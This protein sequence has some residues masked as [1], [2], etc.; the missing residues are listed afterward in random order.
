MHAISA[1]VGPIVGF[2]GEIWVGGVAGVGDVDIDKA[3][4][5]KVGGVVLLSHT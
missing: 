4:E 5:G 3:S 1:I 2:N